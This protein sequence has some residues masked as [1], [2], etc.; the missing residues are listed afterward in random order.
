MLLVCR[1]KRFTLWAKE[2]L[3]RPAPKDPLA[4]K[5]KKSRDKENSQQALVAAIRYMQVLSLCPH[6]PDLHDLHH[7]FDMQLRLKC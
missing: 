5:A 3:S 2:V 4:K 1:Y 6:P 7:K